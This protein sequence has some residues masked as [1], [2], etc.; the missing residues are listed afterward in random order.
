[1][2]NSFYSDRT[3]ARFIFRA[4]VKI[5]QIFNRHVK[6]KIGDS[7][8]HLSLQ[9][10]YILCIPSDAGCAWIESARAFNSIAPREGIHQQHP[11]HGLAKCD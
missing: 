2:A 4:L 5:C 3:N 1:M 9:E 7:D 10:T 11:P 6:S 8:S